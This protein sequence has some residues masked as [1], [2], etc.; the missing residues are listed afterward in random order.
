M[1]E[2]CDIETLIII[3]IISFHYIYYPIIPKSPLYKFTLLNFDLKFWITFNHILSVINK[4]ILQIEEIRNRRGI[5][6]TV[7]LHMVLTEEILSIHICRYTDFKNVL[8]I[9]VKNKKFKS[10]EIFIFPQ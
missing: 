1:I 9:S 8:N 7:F 4:N 2:I 6:Y 3:L 10:H 5:M